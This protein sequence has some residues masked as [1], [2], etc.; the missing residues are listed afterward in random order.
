[1][2]LFYFTHNQYKERLDIVQ[3]KRGLLLIFLIN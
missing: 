1:M 2:D 3:V